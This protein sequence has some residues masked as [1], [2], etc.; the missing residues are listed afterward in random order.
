MAATPAREASRRSMVVYGVVFYTGDTKMA[1]RASGV[2]RGDTSTW[3]GHAYGMP[4]RV[5]TA[6]TRG[7]WAWPNMSS[8]SCTLPVT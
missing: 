8:V 2:A 7:D 6:C 1:T 5:V 4:A 3:L